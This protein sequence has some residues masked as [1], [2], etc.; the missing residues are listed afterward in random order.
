MPWSCLPSTLN[1]VSYQKTRF[2]GVEKLSLN[3]AFYD[4]VLKKFPFTEKKV[5]RPGQNLQLPGIPPSNKI[6][7]PN[8]ESRPTVVYLRTEGQI[9]NSNPFESPYSLV[10][11]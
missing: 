7:L 11:P 1:Y 5:L 3:N 6:Q 9:I 10:F 4:D 8:H 2:F